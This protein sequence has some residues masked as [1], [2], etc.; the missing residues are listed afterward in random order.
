MRQ[1]KWGLR[2]PLACFVP[3]RYNGSITLSTVPMEQSASITPY[4]RDTPLKP[5]V[6]HA[7]ES[8][9]AEISQGNTERL[10]AYLTLAARF[11]RRS[12]F[13][14]FL[15]MAQA[16]TA[17]AV[18]SFEEWAELGY[19]VA[20]GARGIR[21][22]QNRT[23]T[24]E[25]DDGEREQITAVV[26]TAVFDVSQ[27]A[28]EA[29]AAHP[30][31][32]AI[33][34]MPAYTVDEL[35]ARLEAAIAAEGL[36]VIE[37]A[38]AASVRPPRTLVIREGLASPQRCAA[39]LYAYIHYAARFDRDR[40]VVEAAEQRAHAAAAFHALVLR[41]GFTSRLASSEIVPALATQ[42][43]PLERQLDSIRGLISKVS[44]RTEDGPISRASHDHRAQE[45][46]GK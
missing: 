14:Q 32:D 11:P 42:A 17:R 25:D 15:L 29:V 45:T 13:N 44:R 6:E 1:G 35:T 33:F 36:S 30:V 5:M 3:I 18:N 12:L 34:G 27:L 21:L 19:P 16:P 37:G 20:K 10:E 22:L 46:T 43:E 8:M 7:L 28:D 9:A 2:S 26:S 31:P 41:Y 23:W 39:L 38:E 24:R 4:D 40:G